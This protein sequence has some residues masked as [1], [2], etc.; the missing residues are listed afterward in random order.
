MLHLFLE[1]SNR[2]F[3]TTENNGL[4][5]NALSEIPTVA[6]TPTDILISNGV[7]NGALKVAPN[8]STGTFNLNTEGI[9]GN[10]TE[11]IIYDYTGNIKGKFDGTQKQFDVNYNPG[12]YVVLLKTDA[13]GI[14]SQKI[15]IK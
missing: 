10:I 2:V 15:I 12:M 11:I 9:C 13:D 7:N 8:P 4:Y 3:V 6:V 14:Y 1:H 5:S